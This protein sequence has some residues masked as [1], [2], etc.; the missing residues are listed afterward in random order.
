MSTQSSPFEFKNISDLFSEFKVDPKKGLT[1]EEV[2]KRQHKD[3]LNEIKEKQPSAILL[4]LKHFWG[5]TAIMLE[6]T[7][8]LS[9]MLHKYIDAYL[10]STLMLFNAC[11]GFWQEHKAAKAVDALKKSLQVFCRVLRDSAWQ[12]IPSSELVKGDIIRVRSGDFMAADAK[13]ID[14]FVD[15]DESAL[16]GESILKN[17]VSEGI[18]Y[19]GSIVKNG[20]CNALITAIGVNTFY[21]KTAQLIQTAKPHLH[22]DEVVTKV[23]KILSSIVIFFVGST[24]TIALFHHESFISMLPLILIL[25][26][27]AIPVALPAMITISM[28]EGSKE[29]SSKGVLVSRLSATEDAATLT[30]LC[31]DKT[32]TITQ[33][34]L[35]I[36]EIVATNNY[37]NDD[38]LQYAVLASV[39]ANNDPIDMS[40]I[41]KAKDAKISISDFEQIAFIPFSAATKRTEATIRKDGVESKI[42]KGAYFTIRGLTTLPDLSLDNKVNEWA[43]RGFRTI[44]VAKEQDGKTVLIGIAALID[45][46]IADSEQMMANIRKLG[47]SIKMLTGDALPIAKEIASKV[48]IGND[49]SSSEVF[50]TKDK[51][52]SMYSVIQAHNG[53]AEVLPEDKFLI[54]KTLQDNKEITG[55][56][57]D[58]VNDAPALKQAEVGIAVMTATDVAKQAASV[59][60]LKEGLGSI[61]NLITVGR[62][63]HHRISNWIVSKISKTLFTVVFVCVSYL[64]SGQF[65]VSAFS[66]VLLLFIIDFVTLSLSTDSV[67]SSE[68]PETWNIKPL[69]K[70]GFSLGGLIAIESMLWLFVGKKYMGI[71]TANDL[72]SFG[73]IILAFASL[74]NILIIRES[75]RFYKR[76]IGKIVL[77]AISA[78]IMLVCIAIFI[79]IPGLNKLSL[80][81]ILGTLFYSGMCSFI[82]NDSVKILLKRK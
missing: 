46:P 54:V 79:G 50:H 27:S 25:L 12:Q 8:I 71:T 61:I 52:L 3:G 23:V 22:M 32:G 75:T 48:G 30:T 56:T 80:G 68:K 65:I 28:A 47:I 39:A 26:V 72:N 40:F 9:F 49:I 78:D 58:G 41:S 70:V 36:Q 57:G 38:V 6:I 60:L 59:I 42:I 81:I 69:I 24:I 5:L 74:F 29:L 11:I 45:L 43:S 66:M 55:M 21:G 73:F 62:T 15:A 20:E 34:K 4:F 35:S 14:G 17:K 2:V 1:K 10:I 77:Y 76:K 51:N 53:F 37:T 64:L 33:N 67:S 16:T 13:I 44:A 31:I 63:I 7:I 18:L 19:S 82:I